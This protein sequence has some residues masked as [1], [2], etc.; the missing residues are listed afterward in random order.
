MPNFAGLITIDPKRSIGSITAMVTMEEV[1]YLGKEMGIGER[2]GTL[3]PGH[4]RF[5]SGESRLK[6]ITSGLGRV[7]FCGVAGSVAGVMPCN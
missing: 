7:R 4:I 3:S 5:Q 2:H 6:V 1:S